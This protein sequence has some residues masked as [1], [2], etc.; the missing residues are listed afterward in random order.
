M[1]RQVKPKGEDEKDEYAR[2]K[3]VEI[4]DC[5]GRKK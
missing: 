1:E 4:E 5:R 2:L 3:D